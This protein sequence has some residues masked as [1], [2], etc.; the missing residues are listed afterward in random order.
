M[1]VIAARARGRAT[2]VTDHGL[3]GST[4]GGLLPRLF[5]SFLLVSNYSAHELQAPRDRTRVIYGGADPQRYFPDPSLTRRGVLFVG[6]LTP[7]K[8]VDTLLQALPLDA[9]LNVVGT[10]GHDPRPPERDY[11][12]RLR[13]LAHGRDVHFLGRVADADLPRLYRSASVLV[14]PS[15]QRT[16]FGKEV[17]VSELL[18]LTLLEAM[19]SGTPVIASRLGGVPEIVEHGVTGFLI[20][21]GNTREL[22]ERIAQLV[23][24]PALAQRMGAAAREHV[25]AHFTWQRVAERCL[26]AYAA[27]ARRQG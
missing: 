12:R 27:I 25:L 10:I 26:H 1:A 2:A 16:C 24:D 5:D 14:L 17:R 11:P 19:A 23:S 20:E 22:Y 7:H 9:T 13:R 6:R 18:G 3:P 8:G 15:V 21:P 4:W